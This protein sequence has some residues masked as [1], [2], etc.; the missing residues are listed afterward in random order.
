MSSSPPA[1]TAPR[2][3]LGF[4][5]VEALLA[6]I[7]G[8]LVVVVAFAT[9]RSVNRNRAMLY[10]YEEVMAHGRYALRRIRLDL[11]N[12]YLGENAAERRFRG[13]KGQIDG[14][15]ADRMTLFVISDRKV[16][17]QQ[18]EGDLYEVEYGISENPDTGILFLS[19]RCAPVEDRELG[20]E[21]GTLTRLAR[22]IRSLTFEFD[23][24]GRWQRQ[25]RDM[26]HW[27]RRVRITLL[28]QDPDQEFPELEMSR[29]IALGPF[30]RDDLLTPDTTP[31]HE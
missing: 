22:H 26:E 20:N 31:E 11:A 6:T 3:R 15:P 13:V 12:F 2:K 5:L 29:E 21:R 28:L 9:F 27:P 4:T 17:P 25:W 19:R 23:D 18:K 16:H 24:E 1:R 30:R 7:I 8:A 14:R 10:H